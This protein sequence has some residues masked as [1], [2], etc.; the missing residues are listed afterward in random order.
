[1]SPVVIFFS[2]RQILTCIRF[3]L[4][5]FPVYPQPSDE[6]S[7]EPSQVPSVSPSDVPSV[8]PSD[9]PSVSPS[10][11]PSQE[12]SVSPSDEPSVTPSN[13]P[14]QVPSFE[15]SVE[16]SNVPTQFMLCMVDGPI[17]EVVEQAIEGGFCS[18]ISNT[19]I[20]Q[21][22]C[23]ASGSF[24]ITLDTTPS[25]TDACCAP[26]FVDQTQ[27]LDAAICLPGGA[28]AANG[29]SPAFTGQP[30]GTFPGLSRIQ[31]LDGTF[32]WCSPP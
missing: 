1:M 19:G 20:T 21:S 13:V 25:R 8:S 4:S 32:R 9:V 17:A 23:R 14:S 6:P 7:E 26:G 5:T 27:L 31:A 2:F 24:F 22:S 15:P 12:P 18:T 3:L 29:G 28:G 10:N 16:P 11:V 30:A